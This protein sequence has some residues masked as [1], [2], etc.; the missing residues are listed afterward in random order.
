MGIAS[1]IKKI[2]R[3]DVRPRKEASGAH[4]RLIDNVSLPHIVKRMLHKQCFFAVHCETY[5]Y[6]QY[7][8]AAYCKAFYNYIIWTPI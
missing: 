6:K 1:L 3:E 8:F 5:L 2:D 7:F 4:R